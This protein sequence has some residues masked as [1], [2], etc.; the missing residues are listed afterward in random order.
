MT[1]EKRGVEN[2]EV[3]VLR[4]A[5]AKHTPLFLKGEGVQG[6]RKTFFPAKKRFPLPLQANHLFNKFLTKFG[7]AK[8]ERWISAL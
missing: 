2:T 5:G 4:P 6:E 7:M 3:F 8:A 1:S